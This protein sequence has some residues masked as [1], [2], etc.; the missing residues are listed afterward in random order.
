MIAAG[1]VLALC[2]ACSGSVNGTRTSELSMAPPAGPS[3]AT[4]SGLV[5]WPVW[6]FD[7]S[8]SNFNSAEQT[9]TVAN[10]GQLRR[11]W[12][13]NLG[14]AAADS[15][16]IF[17]L[18]QRPRTSMLFTTSRMGTTF[19]IDP[20]N[21]RI[22]WKFVT[23]GGRGTTSS[24]AA[25]PSGAWIYAPGVDGKVH[26]LN[27]S[28]GA[29]IRSGGFPVVISLMPKTEL[30][31]SP[32]NVANGYLYATLGGNGSD[33]PPYDGHVVSVRLKD[34][35]ATIFNSLC[36]QYH[37]L[38]GPNGCPE[39][40]SGIW[41]R[42]GAV[43]D[44]DPSMNG[45][46]YVATGNGDFSANSGGYDYGDSVISLAPDLSPVIGSY[47][48]ADYERLSQTDLDLGSSA[49][50]VLPRQPASQ[51]PLMLVQGG[52]D[53]ILRLINRAPLPGV[54][55]ELQ[56]VRL[57]ARLFS[58][59]AVWTDSSNRVW[60][61]LGLQ[62]DVHAYRLETNASGVSRLRFRW[63]ARPGRTKRG[64][65]PVVANGIV[66]V[67]FNGAIVALNALSGAE[68]WSS[69]LPGVGETIGEVHFE[70][71]IV[72]NGKLYCTDQKG[73]VTAYGLSAPGKH[74]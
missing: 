9:L 21:G 50:V 49:P 5:G 71:P 10:V 1:C 63:S 60:I 66:F 36:S 2:V 74:H 8:R 62:D 24:P 31:E 33:S 26:K 61:F 16:P 69:A 3:R 43:V 58:A 18:G 45:D 51:T 56:I 12:R 35:R 41:A 14:D 64:T 46:I 37:R 11:Q 70:S 55:G 29:E 4:Q 22:I 48:P 44:P 39:Q 30:D 57:R 13:I 25:D 52:K 7:P 59:P 53:K 34:G 47:T 27:A 19:G 65:S 42:G 23:T 72:V 32:L 73:N 28:T 6:G 68:L 15:A 67:A 17:L 20:S 40:R 38:L 54:G